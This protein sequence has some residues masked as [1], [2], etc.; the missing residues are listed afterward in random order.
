MVGLFNTVFGYIVIFS[1]MYGA[2]FDPLLANVIGYSAGL[3]LSYFLNRF[4]T[5]QGVK[6]KTIEFSK[7]LI[8]FIIAYGLNLLTLYF[9]TEH[10]IVNAAYA[11]IISGIF[12]VVSS[13]ILQKY[14]VFK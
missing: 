9:L 8:V 7:F 13:F 10:S 3:S 2:R 12:Y 14:F 11:Q 5:F 6:K 4:F 1:L